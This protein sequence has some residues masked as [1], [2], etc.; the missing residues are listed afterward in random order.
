MSFDFINYIILIW[1][2]EFKKLKGID[3][4]EDKK[5]RK[6]VGLLLAKFKKKNKDTNSED[7]LEIFRTYFREVLQIQD[8]WYSKNMTLSL[9][10]SK[11]NE[12]YQHVLDLRR[13]RKQQKN[14][15]ETAE[16]LKK[17][18]KTYGSELKGTYK[19]WQPDKSIKIEKLLSK[20][21]FLRSIT[22][23]AFSEEAY[24]KY[25]KSFKNKQQ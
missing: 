16:N 24:I 10:N 14:D 17:M 7:M 20:I 23:G 11:I 8:P 25:V 3:Y 18:E 2:E 4:Y 1:K 5:D 15:K 12:I 13:V 22:A 6:A 21:E 19:F 9:L